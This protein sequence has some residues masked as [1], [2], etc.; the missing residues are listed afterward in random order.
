V[1]ACSRRLA[2][3]ALVAALAAGCL[4]GPTPEPQ[5]FT[6][7]SLAPAD[8]APVAVRPELGLVLGQIDLPR[9]LDRAELVTRTG[10]HG[11]RVWNL[12]RWG[13][14]LRTDVARVV[15]DD[16]ARLL[17]TSR[18]AVYPGEARFA[19]S[20]RVLLELLELGGAPGNPV[21]LRARWTIAGPDGLA[22]AVGATALEQ[23]PASASW[24][25]YV[26]AHRIAL[27]V[28]TREIAE[29]IAALPAS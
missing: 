7:S 25:D 19:V 17:G 24:A 20:Y 14:S 23:P 13:G 28:V 6:L 15:A 3:A 29:R 2:P 26:A 1:N 10:D 22:L 9:Y 12:V 16:L 18:I 27:G 21:V 11:L 4:G 5:Y 8:G